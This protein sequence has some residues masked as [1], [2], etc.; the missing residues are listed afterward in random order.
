MKSKKKKEI[1]V[2]KLI[3]K[4]DIFKYD[5]SKL[6]NQNLVCEPDAEYI[7]ETEKIVDESWDFK[8]ANTKEFTNCFHSYP[9]MMIPQIARRI[10][11]TYG[12]G[13]NLL[14]D[15]YCGTG[16]SLVEANLS[17]INAIGTDI[18]PLA[19]LIAQTK[20]T[21]IDIQVLDLFLHDFFEYVFSISFN[22]EKIESIV[23]PSVKN[24]DFWFSKAVQEKLGILLDYI[25]RINDLSIKNFFKVAF[26][27]TIRESSFTKRGEFKLVRNNNLLKKTDIDVF[28]MIIS[29]LSRNRQGLI[30][31]KNE[32]NPI[33]KSF[34]HDFN[35]V[36]SIPKEIISPNSV[37]IV[38]TSP[39]YGDSRTTVAYGQYSRFANE[40][41]GYKDANKI[42][43]QL[44]GGKR[45]NI[46]HRF[47]NDLLNDVIDVINKKDVTRSKEIVSF[48]IDYE[49]SIKNISNIIKPDGFSCYVVGN[50]TVKGIKIP[51]DEI[52]AELFYENGLV[53]IET[54]MRNI[55]N[56]RMPLRNSP[57]NI[58]GET[59]STMKNEYIVICQKV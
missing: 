28:S 30:D 27:E 53:H 55:P 24:I 34:I 48:Y 45:I 33:V 37:D 43:T 2:K 50:R 19:R 35:T 10:I 4:S 13:A 39:P 22:Y 9:A 26:S 20:T 58:I 23:I 11:K 41:L 29:K 7:I 57:S 15:P 44:M 17:G 18:N 31:F 36:Y 16:T 59:A 8:T 54:I 32:C 6:D 52:T 12:K 14:F 25:E 56:K 21:K 49:N 3:K 38:L 46:N 5:Q 40:W 42:D 1:M 47:R 51:N